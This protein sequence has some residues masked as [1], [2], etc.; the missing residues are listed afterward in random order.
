MSR[1]VIKL[2]SKGLSILLIGIIFL[3]FDLWPVISKAQDVKPLT[4]QQ[5]IDLSIKNSNVLKAAYARND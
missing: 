1:S 5:T 2:F 3:G 4:L